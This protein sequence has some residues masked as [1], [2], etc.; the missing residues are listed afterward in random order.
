MATFDEFYAFLDPHKGIRGKQFEKFVKW[1]LKTDPNWASTVDEVWLWNEYPK[2]WGSDCGI[3]L[4]FTRKNGEKWAVQAK[5]ISPTNDI[6][7]AE[8][9]RSP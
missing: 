2:R 5:C 6:V 1:S 7:F 3:D 9:V 8:S 4:I